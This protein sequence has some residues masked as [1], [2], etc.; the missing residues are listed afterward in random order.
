MVI[1]AIVHDIMRMNV[2]PYFEIA[3]I[4]GELQD[5]YHHSAVCQKVSAGILVQIE[6][7]LEVREFP[8]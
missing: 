6:L 2:S 8:T 7:R 4:F 5:S 1:I 3:L